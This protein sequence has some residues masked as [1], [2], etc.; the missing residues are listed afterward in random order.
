MTR[1]W[2]ISMT[3]L[4]L[5]LGL[6]ELRQEACQLAVFRARR[7]RQSRHTQVGGQVTQ[8]RDERDEGDP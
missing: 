4:G 5:R 8:C 3:E 2:A 6:T 1:S 7:F